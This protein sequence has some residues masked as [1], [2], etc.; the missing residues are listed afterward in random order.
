MGSIRFGP[1]S[2]LLSFGVAFGLVVALAL[3]L[4]PRNRVANRLLAVLMVVVA[5]TLVPYAIGY[6][7]FFDAFPGLSFVP[8]DWRL[9]LGP[10]LWLHVVALTRGTLPARWAWHLLPAL[11]QGAYYVA[12]FVQ[13]LAWKNGWDA[14][15]HVPWIDPLENALLVLS[16]A[17]YLLAAWRQRQ[18]YMQ[19]LDGH[20]SNAED[21]RFTAMRNLILALAVALLLWAGFDVATRLARLDYFQRFPLYAA[22][23]GLLYVLG[24]E[25]WRQADRLHPHPT[26]PAPPAAPQPAAASPAPAPPAQSGAPAAPA[27][28]PDWAVLG[29]RW[30]DRTLEAGWWRDP[31]LSLDRLARH[32]GTNTNYLSRAFNEGLGSNFAQVIGGLRVDWVQQQMLSRPEPVELLA[33]AFE[34]GFSSKTSFN[35]VF[36]TTT[37]QAPSQWRAAAAGAKS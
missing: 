13:P 36:E 12:C 34:A 37:G 22:L 15:V 32:L 4:R 6:A 5:L 3:W 11:V 20:V 10:L 7:G 33:L 17:G 31:E 9:A 25:G 16:L 18:A 8:V 19:W 26:D 24:L 30:R 27:A 14:R 23:M 28:A 21:H 2:T 35:R 1:W 29:T